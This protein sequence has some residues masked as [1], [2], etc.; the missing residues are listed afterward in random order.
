MFGGM[1]LRLCTCPGMGTPGVGITECFSKE[2]CLPKGRKNSS[3]SSTDQPQ[4]SLS[5]IIVGIHLRG[6]LRAFV[7]IQSGHLNRMCCRVFK[8]PP[9]RY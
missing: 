3:A 4:W 7:R 2:F 8:S 9:H 6:I 5:T 1:G